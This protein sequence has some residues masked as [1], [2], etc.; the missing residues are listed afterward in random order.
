MAVPEEIRKVPRPKNTAV[1]GSTTN[2]Y[3][4]RARKGCRYI[5]RPDGKVSRIPVEG[6]I[7]GHIIDGVYVAVDDEIPPVG[8]EGE[9]DIKDWGNIILCNNL[10][11]DIYADLKKF[12]NTEDATRLYVMAILRG[13][14]PGI[15]D[16]LLERQYEETFLTE[17]LPKV[18]L[19]K[20]S[21]STFLRNV[22]RSCGRIVEFSRMRVNA[23]SP[24]E[25]IVIDGTLQVNDSTVNSLSAASRKTHL[26]K[27]RNV[28]VMYA[29]SADKREPICSQVYPGNMVDKRIVKAFIEEIDLHTGIV[30]ADK[31]FGM[32]AMRD[33][34]EGRPDVH[35]VVPLDRDDRLISTY[36]MYSFDSRLKDD[37]GITCKKIKA[38][39]PDGDTVWLYSFRNPENA[40]EQ[41]ILYMASHNGDDFDP[42]DY[43]IKK[44]EFGTVVFVSDCD[45]ECGTVY[46]I[47]S[48]R[49]FI[50][51]FYK[52]RKDEIDIDDT[53][54]HSDYSVIA[55]EFVNS[56]ATCCSS[57]M[58]NFLES[59]GILEDMTFGQARGL[60]ERM[61]MTRV[62]DGEWKVRRIAKVDAEAV[63]KLGLINRPV[64]PVEKR[65]RGRPKGSRDTKPRKR[66]TTT[67]KTSDLQP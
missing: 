50:E 14:Y 26:T 55:S 20:T 16:S 3:P 60:L 66:R 2:R 13:C 9:V 52:F 57:R 30:V 63:E 46:R 1:L 53:R 47:Y 11:K 59:K 44:R 56:L 64:V 36:D 19:E 33:A 37:R 39:L 49:W 28:V 31:G 8:T 67:V 48:D 40:M 54:E 25:T 32:K 24:D 22:G 15:P 23:V 5:K 45:L 51:V 58:F 21:V 62:L 35:Y 27:R 12:Y 17:I 4:V 42:N 65:G 10:N 34:L 61:K 41:E 18:N 43:D 38:D 6:E 7:I 29:Y